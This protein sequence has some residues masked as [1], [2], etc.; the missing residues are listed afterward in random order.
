MHLVLL[1]SLILTSGHPDIIEDCLG[2]RRCHAVPQTDNYFKKTSPF[3]AKTADF[4]HG[5]Q[6]VV[7]PLLGYA[8]YT[9]IPRLS[10]P[11]K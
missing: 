11:Q 3:C 6:L 9:K 7:S 1:L 8:S 5:N 10:H 4:R 2:W